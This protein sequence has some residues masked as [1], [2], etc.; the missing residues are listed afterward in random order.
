MA[1]QTTESRLAAIEAEERELW[2]ASFTRDDAW[3]LGVQMREA[4]VAQ[5]L[6]LVIG[7]AIGAQRVFHAALPGASPD[8]DAWLERKARSV[9]HFERSSLGVGELF[10]SQGRLYEADARLDPTV[11]AAN[12]GVFPIQIDGVGVVGT[13]G[14]SGLPQVDDHNFVVDQLR[15][16]RAAS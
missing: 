8:N 5:Q 3:R 11:I 6:P 13:V 14:V 16:F 4:A 12:G 1:K 7:I 2:F 15:K 9:V 10:R